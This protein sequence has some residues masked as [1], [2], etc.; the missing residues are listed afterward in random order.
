MLLFTSEGLTFRYGKPRK[1]AAAH[2]HCITSLSVT[3]NCNPNRSQ[4]FYEKLIISVQALQAMKK[5][6]DI[7]GY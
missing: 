5:L 6:K 1:A 7:K 3:L 4:E 2:I